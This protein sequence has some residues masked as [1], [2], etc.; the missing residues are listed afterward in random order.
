[1]VGT[2][3]PLISSQTCSE[4]TNWETYSVHTSKTKEVI[5]KTTG[6]VNAPLECWR[7]T[8]FP[9]Y[10]ADKFHTYRN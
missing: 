6:R 4:N 5:R 9:R 7:F 1:M 8:N 3:T 2:E 10:H